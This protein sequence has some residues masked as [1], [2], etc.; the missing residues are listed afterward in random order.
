MREVLLYLSAMW[1]SSSAGEEICR[2]SAS[3]EDDMG[4]MGCMAEAYTS[5]VREDRRVVLR[6]MPA[7]STT[8]GSMLVCSA[9]RAA[10]DG[11][12]Q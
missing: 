11:G 9:G 10:D 2:L 5:L 3:G 8:S 6:S 4:G 1:L 7:A 12:G